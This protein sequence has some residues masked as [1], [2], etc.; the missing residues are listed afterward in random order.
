MGILSFHPLFPSG[1][2]TAV[3]IAGQ[4]T[5]THNQN[6]RPMRGGPGMYRA[7]QLLASDPCPQLTGLRWGQHLSALPSGTALSLTPQP[8]WPFKQAVLNTPQPCFHRRLGSHPNCFLWPPRPCP[9]LHPHPLPSHPHLTPAHQAPAPSH[10]N[11]CPA[12]GLSCMLFPL[13]GMP[14]SG[15]LLAILQT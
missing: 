6:D 3:S 15:W 5:E 2:R 7:Q 14:F 12:S 13:P 8:E 11:L 10:T 9:L 4:G 1:H